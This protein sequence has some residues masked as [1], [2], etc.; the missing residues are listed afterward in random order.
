LSIIGKILITEE[1]F[2]FAIK[3]IPSALA[4]KSAKM[5]RSQKKKEV[6]LQKVKKLV[7]S[8][9]SELVDRVREAVDNFDAVYALSFQELRS[10][11]LQVVK[12][13]LI[14]QFI[15]GKRQLLSKLLVV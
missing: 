8:D 7:S 3:A 6:N 12:Q 9:K 1:F 13:R 15:E 2:G 5:P 10:T 14:S 4:K 11:H